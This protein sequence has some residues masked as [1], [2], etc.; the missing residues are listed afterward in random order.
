MPAENVFTRG[1]GDRQRQHRGG[2]NQVF[3]WFH[4]TIVDAFV[5]HSGGK[6]SKNL[7]TNKTIMEN[8][9]DKTLD[10]TKIIVIFAAEITE[11]TN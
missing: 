4:L 11:S 2:Q 7:A 6:V 3:G 8:F 9:W 1:K 5:D 10:V